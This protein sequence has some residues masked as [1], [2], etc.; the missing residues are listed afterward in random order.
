MHTHAH[1]HTQNKHKLPG[2]VFCSGDAPAQ[3]LAAMLKVHQKRARA[4]HR[5][6]KRR[7]LIIEVKI[8]KSRYKSQSHQSTE[9]P[10]VAF[11][12]GE[13][14]AAHKRVDSRGRKAGRAQPRTADSRRTHVGNQPKESLFW[15]EVSVWSS[16]VCMWGRGKFR[17]SV[18]M[19]TDS[20]L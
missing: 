8:S 3:H 17:E 14:V 7:G 5:K 9:Q 18:S 13:G 4:R 20:R 11:V 12:L 10:H 2:P 19:S 6:P 16:I 1:R 15:G